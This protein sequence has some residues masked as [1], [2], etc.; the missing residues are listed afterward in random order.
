MAIPVSRLDL[1]LFR[2]MDAV[3]AHG[4]ISG[5]ARHL[6]L[7]QPAVS[8]ALARLRR[9][10]GDP[11]FVRQG[12]AMVPTE[13][14][15]RVIG[16]VQAHLKGLQ[17][18]L[19][20]ADGFDPATLD[21]TLRVGMRDV[22]EAIALPPLVT[23]LAEQ[24]PQVRLTSVRVPHDV[25]ERSL[26]LGE[27]DLVIDRQRRVSGRIHGERVADET[28]AVLM[29]RDHP[30]AAGPLAL[31]DYFACQHVMVGLQPDRP[32]PLQTVWS[33]LGRGERQVRLRCQHY[34]AAAN[35]VAHSDAL[36]TLPRTYADALTHA[37]PLVVRELQAPIPSVTIWMYW[38]ADREA[39]PVHRWMRAHVGEIAREAMRGMHDLR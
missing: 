12:N 36:L 34:F 21:M 20:Q 19:A 33:T 38:H 30:L 28:L 1:N 27:V 17:G 25:L 31:D 37:L 11:L 35:V 5:A 24:A 39:D 2:V 9:L 23:R 16:E 18:L 22:L 7:S 6:H 4:G 14:T 10:W 8:H 32:D 29:R 13:L 26:T 3:Y 15:R